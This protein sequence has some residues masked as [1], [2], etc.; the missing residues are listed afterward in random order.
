MSEGSPGMN[1]PLFNHLNFNGMVDY[2]GN[3]ILGSSSEIY[4][5]DSYTKG[6]LHHPASIAHFLPDHYQPISMEDYL[7]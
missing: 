1:P 7:K 6:Y 5:I 3:I 2:N 4:N